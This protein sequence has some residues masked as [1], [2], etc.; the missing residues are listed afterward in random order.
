[1][2]SVPVPRASRPPTACCGGPAMT[3]RSSRT[4]APVASA[5]AARSPR[6]STT[7]WK[8]PAPCRSSWTFRRWSTA[9][10]SSCVRTTARH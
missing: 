2:W 6:S 7:P 8:M 9:T 1:M 10:W 5:W 3:F 4:S